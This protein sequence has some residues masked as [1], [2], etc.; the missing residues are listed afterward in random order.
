MADFWASSGDACGALAKSQKARDWVA[1]LAVQ[2]KPISPGFI[3]KLEI[4]YPDLHLNYTSPLCVSVAAV[5]S[6]SVLSRDNLS[7]FSF[8]RA[9]CSPREVRGLPSQD[10]RAFGPGQ[11]RGLVAEY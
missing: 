11:K 7:K 3:A 6:D 5:L 8:D 2:G 4:T 1:V 9:V 10:E